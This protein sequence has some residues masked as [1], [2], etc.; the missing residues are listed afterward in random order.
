MSEGADLFGQE[1]TPAQ[2]ALPEAP[3]PARPPRMEPSWLEV[4][5]AEFAKPY[6]AELREF[7]LREKGEHTIYPPG[8]DIFNAFW[9]TPFDQVRVVI[10]GQ[11]PYHGPNQA[12]GLCFSVMPPVPPPPSLVNIF[13]ELHND[14]HIPMP[15]HGCLTKWAQ[16]GVFLLNTCL[17]VRAHQAHSHRNQGW[18]QFTDCV[19][20]QLNAKRENLVFLLWGSPAQKKLNMIDP[21][22]H[23][24]LTAP[25]PS[26]LS[27]HRGFFGCRHFSAT[28]AH[29]ERLG[30]PPIDWNL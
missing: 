15:T 14:L 11:D 18:E 4:L 16:Q 21:R 29:L 1:S 9:Y 12:H 27:A 10:L 13:R 24:V 30:L 19:I 28:N 17:T 5:E 23:K 6:M 26:P 20:A 7:L 3:K 22:R 8:K 2:P 25:H